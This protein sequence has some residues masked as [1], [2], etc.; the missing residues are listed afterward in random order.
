MA[1]AGKYLYAAYTASNTIATFGVG[2]GC[3]LK[4]L[5]DITAVGLSGGATDGMAA[6]GNILVVAYGDGSIESFNISGGTPVSNGDLQN[7][8]G[9]AA[10][11]WPGGVDI[12]QDGKYAYFGD[13]PTVNGFTTVEVSNISGG[14]LAPTTV[15]GSDGSLGSAI[16]SNNV[17][18]SPDGTV[19]YISNNSSGQV[20]AAFVNSSTGAVT[21]GCTSPTL[22]K[23][24]G[25]WFY[26]GSVS[27]LGLKGNG[28][29]I[30]VAEWGGGLSSSIGVLGL[31]KSGSSC[32][33]QETGYSPITD[34]NSIGL[35]TAGVY[36]PRPY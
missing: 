19:L 9:F 16:N 17:W 27:T 8:T 28:S 31:T 23:Y 35:L 22:R 30:Y 32:T 36:P 4:F 18:L 26:T 3:T 25:T 12:S 6:H 24:F 13:I 7:S 33:L 20:T 11:N 29:P 2:A 21:N 5:G 1:L 10:G 14:S 15:Y 34:A